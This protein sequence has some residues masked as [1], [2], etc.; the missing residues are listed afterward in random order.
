MVVQPGYLVGNAKDRF[1]HDTVHIISLG[2]ASTISDDSTVLFILS[3]STI[4]D[5]ST[6]LFI[7][8]VSTIS[9]ESTVLF[10]L[11]RLETRSLGLNTL[12][13]T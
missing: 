9:D 3:V 8:S 12:G 10:I 4:S 6:V 7:L 11:S 13:T 2:S 5:D 1:S